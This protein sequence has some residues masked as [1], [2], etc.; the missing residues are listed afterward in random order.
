MKVR[1]CFVSN[2]SSSSFIVLVPNYKQKTYDER[3]EEFKKILDI[4]YLFPSKEHKTKLLSAGTKKLMDGWRLVHMMW[5]FGDSDIRE[6]LSEFD[7]KVWYSIDG[8]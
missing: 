7:A 5:E 8:E 3:M 2:S 4:E 6:V 1:T